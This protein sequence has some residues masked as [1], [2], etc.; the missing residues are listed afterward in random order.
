ML[1]MEPNKTYPDALSGNHLSQESH[2][3]E[4][5]HESQTQNHQDTYLIGV[6][7]VDE[8]EHWSDAH[9]FHTIHCHQDIPVNQEYTSEPR[10]YHVLFLPGVFTLYS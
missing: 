3:V 9:R 7:N 2:A 1:A 4:H 8:P 5:Y 6:A 10:I